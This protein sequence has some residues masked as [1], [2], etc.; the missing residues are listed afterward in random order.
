LSS[1]ESVVVADQ[2][3]EERQA[4]DERGVGGQRRLVRLRAR[5]RMAGG[6][7]EHADQRQQDEQAL[8]LLV[9]RPLGEMIRRHRPCDHPL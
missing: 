9:R 5:H 2:V 8:G 3:G 4:S 6:G 1:R 7:L